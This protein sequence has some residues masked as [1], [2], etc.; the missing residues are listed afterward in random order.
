MCRISY[1]WGDQKMGISLPPPM[2]CHWTHFFLKN[3]FIVFFFYKLT[4]QWFMSNK[5]TRLQKNFSRG[6]TRAKNKDMNKK[7]WRRD[8]QWFDT[9]TKVL[10]KWC[11][12]YG[13][14]MH[15]GRNIFSE[16]WR[17]PPPQKKHK[18]VTL[19][20]PRFFMVKT[21]IFRRKKQSLW[22]EKKKGH[23]PAPPLTDPTLYFFG[24]PKV[25]FRGVIYKC[26]IS[27]VH[28]E[29][30]LACTLKT[31]EKIGPTSRAVI[32]E[33]VDMIPKDVVWTHLGVFWTIKF[34]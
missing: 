32:K 11:P 17:N 7:W 16:F 20:K 13:S 33:G 1:Y 4:K 24:P 5:K 30:I 23:T 8:P 26:L 21:P 28:F 19:Q 34:G 3:S 18:K 9:R 25:Y 10:T 27:R 6:I 22:W 12:Y 2:W 14:F 15:N 29:V 31:W